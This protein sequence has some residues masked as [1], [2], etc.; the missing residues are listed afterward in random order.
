MMLAVATQLIAEGVRV[1]NMNYGGVMTNIAQNS[2]VPGELAAKAT[3][4]AILEAGAHSEDVNV[5]QADVTDAHGR[6]HIISSTIQ[7]FG[8][9]NR[10]NELLSTNLAQNDGVSDEVAAKF[11]ASYARNP[12]EVPSGRIAVPSE[13]ATVIAFLA[14]ESQSSYIV[15]QTIVADGEADISATLSNMDFSYIHKALEASL[16]RV[17]AKYLSRQELKLLE[18]AYWN[19]TEERAQNFSLPLSLLLLKG[20]RNRV[21]FHI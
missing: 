14:D 16:P 19:W 21:V 11:Y 2:G 3:K 8:K 9:L 5:L 20:S 10:K 12:F 15:G 17:A 4:K 13:I 1:N 18:L 6:K 7:V